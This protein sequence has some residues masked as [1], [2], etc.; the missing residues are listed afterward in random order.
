MFFLYNEESG[1][2]RVRSK[3][4]NYQF[5]TKTGHFARWGKTQEDDPKVGHLEIFDLEVSDIC[6]GIPAKGSDVATP[7]SFCYKS[8]TKSGTN[9]SFD[10]FKTIFDKLPRTLCQIAFGIGDIGANPD[11]VRMM[12]YCRENDRNPNVVPNLTINGY[13]LTDEWVDTLALLCGG[14]AVSRYDNEDVCYDAVKKLTD[15]GIT[16][17]NIHAVLAEESIESCYKL[18]RD[19][20]EDVR[21]AQV[22]AV[23]FLTLKPMGKRNKWHTVK[24]IKRYRDLV[25]YAFDYNVGVGFDSCSAPTFLAAMKDHPMY[26]QLAQMSEC[27]E[28]D[29][30]SGYANVK[31]EWH[32]CSFSENHPAWYGIDL[33][34]INNFEE[35]VWNAA[36]VRKFRNALL[37]QDNSHVGNEVYLCPSYDLYD[38]KIGKARQ[39]I[40]IK[41]VK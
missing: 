37:R 10:T 6:N 39:Y 4:Y 17:V 36:P 38:E 7:C 19:V 22:K 24:D 3:D 9:M 25:Q 12:E 21:L 8:N 11:L 16:Q 41:E 29:R 5:N 26:E 31:G 15:A 30:F 32:H 18:I 28:S 20:A 13:G 23:V 2:K 14:I 27:C 33:L 34:K 1:I 40:P 35:E